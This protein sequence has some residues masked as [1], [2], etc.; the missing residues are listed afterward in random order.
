LAE[1]ERKTAE[2]TF[3]KKKKFSIRKISAREKRGD[4][5]HDPGKQKG[6]KE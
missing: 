3:H 2:N 1:G 5:F 6:K 4:L